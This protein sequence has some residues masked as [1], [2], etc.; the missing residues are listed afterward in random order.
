MS[1]GSQE[2]VLGHFQ[3]TSAT[4]R[5]REC[6]TFLGTCAAAW[7]CTGWARHGELRPGCRMAWAE[8][9]CL[10]TGRWAGHVGVVPMSIPWK[11]PVVFNTQCES[12]GHQGML[13]SFQALTQQCAKPNCTSQ[14]CGP[15]AELM[16]AEGGSNC[17]WKAKQSQHCDYPGS[18]QGLSDSHG[19]TQQ[20]LNPLSLVCSQG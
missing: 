15:D 11:D 19:R 10:G 2:K 7:V 1:H 16:M 9:W 13:E 6:K 3:A 4:W 8:T 14:W 5:P 18:S 17:L 20:E 12:F